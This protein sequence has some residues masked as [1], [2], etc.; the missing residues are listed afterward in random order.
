[1]IGLNKVIT[2]ENF[3]QNSTI[4]LD[5]KYSFLETGAK[6]AFIYIKATKRH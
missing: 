6:L 4:L 2:W 3:K 5:K 1:M